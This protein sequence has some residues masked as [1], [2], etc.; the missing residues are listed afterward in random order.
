MSDSIHSL[1]RLPWTSHHGALPRDT[2]VVLSTSLCFLA[3]VLAGHDMRQVLDVSI[4]HRDP[5]L[6][7]PPDNVC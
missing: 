1:S 6:G 3:T 5:P 2:N 7:N 4:D